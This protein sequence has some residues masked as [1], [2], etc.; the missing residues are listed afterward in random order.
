MFEDLHW[1]DSETQALLDGLVE[2]L[3]TAPALLLVNYRPEYQHG[4]GGKTYYAQL[5][6][7][8]LPQ[9]RADELLQ[10]LLGDDPSV[11]SLRLPLIKRTE[12]NPFFLEESVRALVETGVLAGERGAY[13]LVQVLPGIQVPATVQAVLAARIDRLPPDR[14]SLL[15]TAAVIGKDVPFAVLQALADLS[16]EDLR[17]GLTHLQAAEFLYEA[18]L[19]PELEFTFKHTLTHEVAY[20]SLLQERRRVLHARIVDAIEQLHADR[21]AEQ[22]E[23]LAHHA[24]RGETWEKAASYLRQAG[25]KAFAC[26]ANREAA[27][28]LEQALVALRHLPESRGTL[29]QM[30]D[31]QLDL[32]RALF[33][34]GDH[35]RILKHLSEA[36]RLA[37]ALGDERRLAHV[38][39]YLAAVSWTLGDPER[40]LEIG[41][42]ARAIAERLGD[43]ALQ[44]LGN[45]YLGLANHQRGDYR[46]AIHLHGTNVALLQGDLVYERFG[47]PSLPSVVSRHWLAWSLGEIGEFAEGMLRAHEAIRIAELV[48]QP[49]S[50]IIAYLCLGGLG[51]QKGDLTVAIPALQRSLGFSETWNIPLWLPSVASRLGYVYALS[52]RASDALPL[53]ERAADLVTSVRLEESTVSAFLGQAYLLVGRT[54]EATKL[55]ERVLELVR[56]RGERGNQ[57]WDLHLLGELAARRDPPDAQRAEGQ[58]RESLVLAEELGMRPLVAHCHLGLSKLYRRTGNGQQAHEHLT[59][60]TTMYR[61]MEM[62]LWL[63]QTEAALKELG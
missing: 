35:G 22:V 26:S 19:F 18:T 49:F 62:R 47:L 25:A 40:A 51:L 10:A 23:R 58:Y 42:R 32:R 20:G 11:Q 63:D 21:L 14:K 24:F 37:E 28:C 50:L 17:Q 15:Q 9:E 34:L 39:I 57:A 61:E 43:P 13:R 31:V 53:L 5:R 29:E 12:G 54:A 30:I 38:L 55:G 60:A 1:I 59:T 16:E 46:R 52:G 36:E 45:F 4:W 33:P 56:A 6:I 8:P 41:N 27:A 48:D 44:I 3:P 2:S 7:D